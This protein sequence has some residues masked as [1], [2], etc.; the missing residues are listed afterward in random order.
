MGEAVPLDKAC[1]VPLNARV[2]ASALAGHRS[3][4]VGNAGVAGAFTSPSMV[5]TTGKG[6][7]LVS[8]YLAIWYCQSIA[9]DAAQIP[10]AHRY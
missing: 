6:K 10:L 5:V 3:C 2:L 1:F 8:L 7:D 4:D 9:A